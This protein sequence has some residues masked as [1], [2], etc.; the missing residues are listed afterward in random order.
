MKAAILFGNYG[1]N[2]RA[3][4]ED[5]RGMYCCSDW[6]QVVSLLMDMKFD[7]S[8]FPTNERVHRELTKPT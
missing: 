8:V 4:S 5:Y 7:C 6:E 1:W 3:N 2:R